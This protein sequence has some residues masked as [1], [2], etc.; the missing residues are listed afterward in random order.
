M[1]LGGHYVG[2]VLQQLSL[3]Q[4]LRTAYGQWTPLARIMTQQTLK[5]SYHQFVDLGDVTFQVEKREI[6]TAD[7]TGNANTMTKTKQK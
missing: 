7:T 4:K 3:A 5:A 1:G 2:D 6:L